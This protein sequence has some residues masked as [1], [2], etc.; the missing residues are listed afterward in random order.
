MGE[1]ATQQQ[2]AGCDQGQELERRDPAR[3][4]RGDAPLA[5]GVKRDCVLHGSDEFAATSSVPSLSSVV[6]C[7]CT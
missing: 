1:R 5:D 7:G 6:G 2:H 4:E 3:E